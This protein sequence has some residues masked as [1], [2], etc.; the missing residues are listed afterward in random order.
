MSTRLSRAER[1]N[2]PSRRKS[3]LACV[4]SKRRCDQKLPACLRCAQRRIDCEYPTRI[5][6]SR[7][8]PSCA[9]TQHAAQLVLEDDVGELEH[10]GDGTAHADLWMTTG[11]LTP[12]PLFF[13]PDCHEPTQLG[14]EPAPAFET[15]PESPSAVPPFNLPLLEEV[16]HGHKLSPASW[17]T[18]MA[19]TEVISTLPVIPT[20]YINVEAISAQLDRNLSYAVEKMKLAPSTM[21]LDLQ[22]PWCHVSL[23]KDEMPRVMQG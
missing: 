15:M 6:Q 20:G 21:L 23:Y 22:T 7:R 14:D 17:R 2:P 13:Q 12:Y 5:P 8:T 10:V 18:D 19:S 11:E 3:C 16:N 1:E 9:E 4:K